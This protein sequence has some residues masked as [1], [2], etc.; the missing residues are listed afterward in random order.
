M[1]VIFCKGRGIASD[2]IAKVDDTD[3]SHVAL[4]SSFRANQHIVFHSVSSGV[5]IS[6]RSAFKKK[7]DIK[8]I[9]QLASTQTNEDDII[10]SLL[11]MYED[12]KY[13][14]LAL[15]YLGIFLTLRKVGL[16][17]PAKNIWNNRNHFICTE[18]VTLGILGHA[19]SMMS[20]RTLEKHIVEKMAYEKVY[21][22]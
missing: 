11:T 2:I 21:L 10:W 19:D 15:V 4:C 6:S 13:D 17:L 5:K 8:R 3:V 22:F 18:F 12:R 7:Y 9:Y 20:L 16:E 1:D 14:Y